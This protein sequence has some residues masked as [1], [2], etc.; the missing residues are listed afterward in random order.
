MRDIE[1]Y[2]ILLI[3][4]PNKKLNSVLDEFDEG[5]QA[6]IENRPKELQ[7]FKPYLE[8]LNKVKNRT[9]DFKFNLSAD[10]VQKILIDDIAKEQDVWLSKQ[11]NEYEDIDRRITELKE[12][13]E[14]ENELYNKNLITDNLLS[15]KSFDELEKKRK[16]LES[17]SDKIFDVCSQYGI[18]SS[19]V[20][21]DESMISIDELNSMYDD[22]IEFLDKEENGNNV[23]RLLKDKVPDWRIQGIIIIG[24]ILLCYTVVLDVIS[25]VFI[26]SLI[27][28]QLS[29][30]K[31]YKYY[32]IL[33]AI[34]FNIKPENMGYTELDKSLL[35]PTELPDDFI[36]TDERFKIFE[37]EFKAIEE[38]YNS[39]DM[40][41][42]LASTLNE[43]DLKLPS[44]TEKLN[45]YKMIYENKIF[46]IQ[47]DIDVEIKNAEILYQKAKEDWKFIGE[48]YC[49]SY[50]LRPEFSLGVYDDCIEEKVNIG[51]KNIIIRPNGNQAIMNK[52]LQA[53]YVNIISNVQAGKLTTIVYDPNDFGR[54]LMPLFK[55]E[56]KDYIEFVNDSLSEILKDLIIY[57]QSNFKTMAGKTIEEYNKMCEE[58]GITP[59]NYKLLIVL[60]QPK[61]IEED[62][63]LNA[64]FD[65]SATGGVIIW[66]VSEL[67]Q[68]KNAYIFRRPFDGINNPIVDIVNDDWCHKVA[69]NY[70]EAIQKAK[71]KGLGWKDFIDNVWS[72]DKT[73][74]G[75]ASTFIDFYPGYYEG[76]PSEYKP[77]TLGNEGNVHA[78]G[79]GTSGA[80]KS[81][82][83]NHLVNT[84]CRK[85]DPKNLELWLC[86]FKGVEF[87]TY[88][89]TPEHPFA[90]PHIAAC[91]CTSDGDF[92]TSLFKAYRNK[93]DAR[94]EDMKV[95]GVKNMPGWNKKVKELLGQRKPEA[96]IELRG[97]DIGFNPIWTE[98][99]IWPRVLFICDEFQVIFTKAD[100]NNVESIKADIQQIA[101]VARACGMHIFFT[102]QSMK[103][104]V[105]SDILA[106][107]TLRFALR[108][109][110]EVSQDIIGSKRA[111]DIKEKNGYLIVKSLEMKTPEEQ[112]R[113]KTPFLNDSPGSGKETDSQLYDNIKYLND[114][115][116]ERGFKRDNVIT[117]EESTKH[118]I[119]ELV[120]LYEKL[121][122]EEKAPEYGLFFLGNRM[123]Y[124]TNRAPDNIILG[125]KNN[126][127]I[128][129]VFSDLNDFV[130]WFQQLIANINCSVNKGVIMINS[131]VDD[132]SYL[133][134]A[135]KY[136]TKP[137]VYGKLLSSKETNCFEMI[138]YIKKLYERR[139]ET[140]KK[141]TPIWIFLLG[142]DKG[143]GVGVDTDF[144]LRSSM[145][146][147]LQ[148]IGEYNIHVIFINTSLTG[149]STATI[150][151]CK[152]LVA[153]KCSLDDSMTLIGTKQAGVVYEGM[154]TGWLFSKHD[155]KITRDKLYISPIERE[156]KSTE[157]IL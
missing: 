15:N 52:F 130:L 134:Y 83:L 127:N 153:G 26:M 106:N 146:T 108:C 109:E 116:I 101:K 24:I 51:H 99:D 48:R 86:D 18:T 9:N 148:T 46:R 60:S 25:V 117:Y 56:L 68:S 114:L 27:Y 11:E 1:D 67:M 72:D 10:V 118:P 12:S 139:K 124:S 121:N 150:S 115:A 21:I 88:M 152:Y 136:I 66:M 77:Y 125:A 92:A 44:I 8:R 90:L 95:L 137:E 110:P 73:W 144:N 112:K 22:Y 64:L 91:L 122:K 93:A 84:M 140:D 107:F 32:S 70:W 35:K 47:S 58:T 20:D 80:G 97:K 98:D 76:D 49:S 96:L 143:R 39:G 141:D 61:T 3:D 41:K 78:I 105:S 154:D 6:L 30:I 53:M 33:M 131:Q 7:Y 129:S 111:S 13:I 151:A 123:A 31:R 14:R 102:S 55:S 62:E 65:Y 69:N 63:Q 120:T 43:W 23:I 59:I 37:E 155:G 81:V 138:D 57:I 126:D 135:E 50:A 45:N 17:N 19:D 132:L 42:Q 40:E 4:D 133:T 75:D 103:G 82:F 94:Y 149:F 119:E 113:Y 89:N 38:K 79:V 71:P 147:L 142:W 156:I 16:L 34:V 29:N 145:N 54:S 36:D 87:Q 85:Y 28:N 5:F 100:A 157:I 2:I 104:T 128:L 74:T